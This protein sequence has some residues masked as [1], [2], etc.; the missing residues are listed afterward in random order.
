MSLENKVIVVTGGNGL[1]GKSFVKAI[2]KAGGIP[3]IAD[4]NE[5][6]EMDYAYVKLDITSK[7]SIIKAIKY[8]D[9]KYGHIDGL[10]NNAYPRNKNYG[11]LFENVDYEDFCDN[12]NMNL[13]GYF[14]TS[15][16]F[17]TYFQKQGYGNVINIS[18]IYGVITP[19]FEIYN[20]TEMTT[21]VEY[22]AIKSAL[23][24][25]TKYM[26]KYFKGSNIRFNSVSLGGIF[27]NQPDSF[28]QGYNSYCLNKG[29]LDP[30]DINGV[31]IFLLSENSTFIN[32][33]NI[34]VDDGFTL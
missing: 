33:Q 34:I 7:K 4:I 3:V 6:S 32:G 8:I 15:Q 28:I 2:N 25:L 5:K 22:I 9:K 29:M 24:N 13:G 23:I 17:I 19:R 20:N 30:K 18:S 1:L 26:A 10:I 31:I 16:Q 12:L 11:Q 14:L 21:P 27:N